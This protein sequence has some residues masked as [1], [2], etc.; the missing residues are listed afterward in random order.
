MRIEIEMET[1]T[2]PNALLR[3]FRLP[4]FDVNLSEPEVDAHGEPLRH[5]RSRGKSRAGC[6]K[7]KE[8]RVK[9]CIQYSRSLSLSDTE[10]AQCDEKRPSCWNCTKL[11]LHCGFLKAV[12]DEFRT[13]SE[14]AVNS[15]P[16]SFNPSKIICDSLNKSGGMF[17]TLNV[18]PP[19]LSS[20]IYPPMNMSHM[21][22]FHHFRLS[23]PNPWYW[24]PDMGREGGAIC[25]QGNPCFIRLFS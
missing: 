3:C 15:V 1:G 19:P 14:P 2:D 25:F 18:L 23:L 21:H 24:A 4:Q 17:N 6:D 20:G 10:R 8:R 9:V 16:L 7:C 13:D 5:R 11:R 22:L 12:R